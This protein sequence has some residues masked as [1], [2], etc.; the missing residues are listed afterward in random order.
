MSI[1]IGADYGGLD[2]LNVRVD[3]DWVKRCMLME[4]KDIRQSGR[5]RRTW[6]EYIRGD[7]EFWP[8][9]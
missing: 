3:A 9:P 8:D 5:P 7:T 2:I 4:T 6:W 1:T